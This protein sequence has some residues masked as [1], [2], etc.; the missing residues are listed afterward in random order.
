MPII[1][2]TDI[3]IVDKPSND[4]YV[5]PPDESYIPTAGIL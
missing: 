4:E 3:N 2:I 1:K 5:Y